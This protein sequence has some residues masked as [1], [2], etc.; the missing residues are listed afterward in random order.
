M[1]YLYPYCK[2]IELYV[3][4]RISEEDAR[5]QELTAKEILKRFSERP[6]VIL[7]D[8][9][10]MGKT[11]VAL[12][13][14]VS[15]ALANRGRRPVVVMVPPSLR[16]KWPRDF[17][18]FRQKC[19]PPELADQLGA[20]R[21]E[22]AVQ[23]LK[24]LDDPPKRRKQIIFVTHG[25]MSRNLGDK[26]VKLAIVA[27]AIRGRHGV[28]EMRRAL[29]K[30]LGEL[31]HMRWV[32]REGTDIWIE[33]LK[34]PC[35]DWLAILEKHGIDPEDDDNPET[36]DDPVP[37]AV[38]NVLN[39]VCTDSVYEAL[40]EIPLRRTSNY[41]RRVRSARNAIN[42]ELQALWKDCVHG[43]RLQ[44]PL[45]IL[46]EA[47]HL[48]NPNTR[49]ASLFRSADAQDDAEHFSRGPLAGAF[50][51]MLFLTATPFQLGHAELCSVL[52]RFDGISWNSRIAPKSG[53]DGY[54][55]QITKLRLSLDAAQASALNL[56]ASWSR[57]K[58]E[59]LQSGGTQFERVED[60]WDAVQ[61][62][63]GATPTAQIVLRSY[64]LTLLRMRDAE[65]ALKPWVLRH[66][67]PRVMP[68][69]YDDVL[70]RRVLPGK[71]VLNGGIAPDESGLLIHG[72][73]LLPFLLAASATTQAP[74]SRPV[75]AEGLASS[76]EAFLQT[77]RLRQSE[78][79]KVW[80]SDDDSGELPVS[81]EAMRWYL[82]K[83]E[84]LIPRGDAE[85]SR[86]HPKIAA[87]VDRALALWRAGEKVVV[88]CH[89]I[90]TGR[91]LRQRIS[92]AVSHDIR[93]TGARKL[94]CPSHEVYE[95]IERIGKRFFDEDSPIRQAC[96][97]AATRLLD[98]FPALS[99]YHDDLI[100]IVRR[101]IRTPS[102]L[103]RYFPLGEQLDAEAM[104]A[105][106]QTTDDSGLSLE[107]L[108]RDFFEFLVSHCGEEDRR[109]YIEAV[110]AIQTGAHFGRDTSRAFT[111]DELQ[112]EQPEML[113][114]NVRLVN[115]TTKP[116]TRQRLMLT[117]NTPFY[118]EILVTSNVLAEGVDLHLNCRYVIHH[119]LCW[120]PSTL[121]QR[122]G[123][124][125][126]IGAKAERCGRPIHIYL[127]YIAETQDEKMYRVVMDRE[128]WF[129]VVMG[130]NYKVDAKTVEK[131]ASRI[132][133]PVAAAE[134]LA[135]RLEVS[136]L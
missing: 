38:R 84:R 131:L 75:F 120:N 123:R 135:F 94:N 21:A 50:E 116:D 41:A 55:K 107:N 29:A 106:L 28:H 80:D 7:A 45:L 9:V 66:L 32:E 97:E 69:P 86:T 81:T 33:L 76:Y 43:L 40:A 110:K 65:R 105:A 136:R 13:V 5:R 22:R 64:E 56:D 35:E 82:D 122:T 95:H 18:L 88:F 108:L 39:K 60:W 119:D 117:F 112:G 68:Q 15:T 4:G 98:Y 111:D 72:E 8:E 92:E 126:R 99:E 101:N 129:S 1:N 57:L 63:G 103:V 132:P 36:N 25:A 17:D 90:A 115:G 73:A 49:L 51:R 78:I 19:L 102:F 74:E 31:L 77:R 27:Q 20:G 46:D 58:T 26:W 104:K 42:G 125:D 87:T 70:R 30:V 121:E 37:K 109:R 23:F 114:P 47:H 124:I 113:V 91:V 61:H 53:Q 133:L 12:A 52:D 67:K 54:R 14:A 89:Y 3:R 10:G 128:R 2:D 6:G 34:S 71:G 85:A 127:P 11:F 16:E 96:D 118:P 62:K 93:V 134:N 83:L 79:Q 44:L 100:D 59:D 24:L 130:E 48:K